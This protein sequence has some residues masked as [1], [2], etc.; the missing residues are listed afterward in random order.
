MYNEYIILISSLRI[1]TI[2][3]S[4]VPTIKEGT[5]N[6]KI[7]VGVNFEKGELEKIQKI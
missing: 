2:R 1:L 5:S 7:S 6:L 4:R 3:L